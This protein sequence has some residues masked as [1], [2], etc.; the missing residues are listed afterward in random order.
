M[1]SSFGLQGKNALV[2]GAG[3]GIGEATSLALAGAGANVAL[4][5]LDSERAE[6]V[7]QKVRALGVAAYPFAGNVLD[8][9]A[10]DA[11]YAEADNALGGIDVLVTVV[12]STRFQPL[13][14]TSLDDWDIEQN[15]NIRYVFLVAK[16]FAAARVAAGKGGT[17]VFIASVSGIMS[18]PRHAPYGAAKAGLIHLT[19]SM[20]VE[21]AE[22]GIRV[23]AVAPG[24]IITPRL[25][26]TAEWREQIE[27]SPLPL[28]RRGYP[29]EI[30]NA[31]LFFSSQ[32]SS[33]V[34]G[35]VLAVDGGLVSAN[36]MSVP[37]RLKNARG[38]D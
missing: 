23:N 28:Q 7:A 36:V 14:E 30:A 3:Q 29:H 31:V 24:S 5:D 20:A 2:V 13:L 19:K 34:T 32:L 25:P 21:W 4:L 12:G 1:S 22:H 38:G 17:A 33:Y 18:S 15:I 26:D 9:G 37:P 35:Q 11:L 6:A 27:R 10:V 8:D 16:A